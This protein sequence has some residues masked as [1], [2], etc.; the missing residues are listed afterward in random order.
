MTRSIFRNKCFSG[1]KDSISTKT[2]VI[3]PSH[4]PIMLYPSYYNMFRVKARQ[5]AV[6]F[7]ISLYHIEASGTTLSTGPLFYLTSSNLSAQ[8]GRHLSVQALR[9]RPI[10]F[11]ESCTLEERS[12]EVRFSA[13]RESRYFL[14]PSD[15]P[16]TFYKFNRTHCPERL[17]D[18]F[19]LIPD[20]MATY[21]ID[22]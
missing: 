10:M 4:R 16:K 21:F 20:H 22:K 12:W 8:K 18:P 17:F 14:G 2:I 9:W 15:Q 7:S 6:S 19:L 1:I 5:P 11:W 13:G 3:C